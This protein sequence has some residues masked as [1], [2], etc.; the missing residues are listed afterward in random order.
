[1]LYG[2]WF[3]F[4]LVC[5]LFCSWLY[6]Y[7]EIV[8]IF[9]YFILVIFFLFGEWFIMY[10]FFSR[11]VGVIDIDFVGFFIFMFMVVICLLFLVMYYILLNYF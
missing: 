6:I 10:Y 3:I 5:V 4:G 2:Y 8:N 7:N 9:F 11:Y 1:M